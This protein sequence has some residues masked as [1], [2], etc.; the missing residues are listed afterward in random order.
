[1]AIET[2]S[3]SLL[4]YEELEPDSMQHADQIMTERRDNADLRGKAFYTADGELYRTFRGTERLGITRLPQ[5]LVLANL[6]E[7]YESL[8]QTGNYFPPEKAARTSFN[9]DD[10]VQLDIRGLEVIED[11]SEY[12]HFVIDPKNTKGLNSE[13]LR[14][15]VRIY[16]PDEENFG[17]NME[18]LAEEGKM[19]NFYVLMPG[20]VRETLKTANKKFLGRASWLNYFNDSFD[21]D[22][23]SVD[24]RNALRGVR[25]IREADAP[26]TEVPREAESKELVTLDRILG[27]SKPFVPEFGWEDW[28]KVLRKEYK[29]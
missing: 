8:T 17:Q 6:Q 29:L 1:M 11:S 24:S 5:N 3:G 2:I 20:Y 25:R 9:H 21:A 10:T 4:A 23:R 13:Q 7:A 19:P 18:R 26:K 27:I 28:E 22:D 14:A 16:G 15:A 12:G